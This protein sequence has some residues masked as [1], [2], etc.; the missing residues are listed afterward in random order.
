MYWS[1]RSLFSEFWGV[2]Y[3]GRKGL[4]SIFT[5]FGAG[6]HDF[7]IFNT[8]L[9]YFSWEKC[10]NLFCPDFSLFAFYYFTSVSSIMFTFFAL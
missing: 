8:D 9:F 7:L 1:S 4:K 6:E 10:D 2:F 5:L 3:K